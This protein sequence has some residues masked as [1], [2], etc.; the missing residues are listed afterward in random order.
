VVLT[1]RSDRK[2]FFLAEQ[3]MATVRG[4]LWREAIGAPMPFGSRYRPRDLDEYAGTYRFRKGPA[5]VSV[6]G[7]RLVM[8]TPSRYD[9]PDQT[10]VLRAVGPDQFMSLAQG[11]CITFVRDAAGAV[12]RFVHTGYAYER[13]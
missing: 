2:A 10:I 13:E 6:D 12:V 9:G 3:L 8:H 5:R 1:N 4:P 7:E 11:Q